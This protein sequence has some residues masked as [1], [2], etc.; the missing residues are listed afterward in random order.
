MGGLTAALADDLEIRSQVRDVSKLLDRALLWLHE[1]EVL[2]ARQGPD[3]LPAGDDGQAGAGSRRFN[4][5][6]FEPLRMHYDE[7]TLQ[8]HIMAEYARQGL[9]SIR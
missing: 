9:A 1:Q 4:Q 8:I 7:Q 5:S 6:D 2:D 3:R